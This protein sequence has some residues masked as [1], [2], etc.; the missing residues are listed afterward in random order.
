MTKEVF[1]VSEASGFFRNSILNVF[2]NLK[3]AK[4]FIDKY[5]DDSPEELKYKKEI[6][7][8]KSHPNIVF[9]VEIE[10]FTHEAGSIRAWY[11]VRKYEVKG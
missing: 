5:I 2:S 11:T 9:S 3:A 1:I 4:D 10:E 8:D 6:P 7:I